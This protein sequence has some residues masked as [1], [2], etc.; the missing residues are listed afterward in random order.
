VQALSRASRFK[1]DLKKL[2]AMVG[3]MVETP[4]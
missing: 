2:S 1:A 3:K 4:E